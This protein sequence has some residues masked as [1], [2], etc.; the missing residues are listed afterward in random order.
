MGDSEARDAFEAALRQHA[1]DLDAD[2]LRAIAQD[3]ERTADKWEASA[4]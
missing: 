3:L 4:L 2:D 1:Q